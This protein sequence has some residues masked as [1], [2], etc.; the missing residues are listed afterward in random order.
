M[1]KASNGTEALIKLGTFRPDLLI[2]D[3]V[4]PE[5]DGIEVCRSI[6][7]EP[8]LSHVRVIVITG[9][10]DDTRLEGVSKM[11]FSNIFAKPL[12]LESFL[13]EVYNALK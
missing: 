6:R 5:I 12:E 10:P 7:E 13:K 8:E 2:L 3:I 4:M 1:E 9:F 11:G